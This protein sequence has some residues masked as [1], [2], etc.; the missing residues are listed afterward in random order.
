MHISWQLIVLSLAYVGVLFIIAWHGDRNTSSFGGAR[1]S[2]WVYPL[3][4]GVY[5][6]SW[7]YYG[8]VGSAAN[9][10]WEF[11]PIYLGPILVFIYGW[12]I[13]SKFNAVVKTHRVGSLADFMSARYGRSHPLAVLT[14]VIA[15]L[16]TI[17]YIALQLKA[18]GQTFNIM[19]GSPTGTDP[20]IF[21]TAFFAA[22]FLTIFAILFG[23]RLPGQRRDSN[24]GMMIAIAFESVV[25][26][27]A[28]VLVGVFCTFE[29]YDGFGN[30]FALAR[31]D[32][33]VASVF[34]AD[35][36]QWGL[37][38]QLVLAS[39]AIICLPRQFHV[40]FV[41]SPD[42]ERHRNNA[43]WFFP[44]YLLGFIIF[45]VPIAAAGLLKFGGLA[46]P[47]AFVLLLP[48]AFDNEPLAALAF[49]G[50]LS[51]ATGMILVSTLALAIM[52]SNELLLPLLFRSSSGD[53]KERQDLS[54]IMVMVRRLSIVG[55]M[56]LAWLYY[57]SATSER[58]LASIGL[59]A[60]A[61]AAQFAPALLGGLYWRQGNRYGALVGMLMGLVSWLVML[62]LPEVSDGPLQT[63]EPLLILAVDPLTNGV[64]VSLGL[65]LLTYIFV[66]LVTTPRLVD[67]VQAASFVDVMPPSSK[68]ARYL[69]ENLRID[70]LTT[71]AS[72][73]IGNNR[74][75]HIID[76]YASEHQIQQLNE[77]DPAPADL[78]AAIESVLAQEIGYTSARLVTRSASREKR[79]HLGEL[80]SLVDEAST[81]ARQNQELLRKAI[82]HLS[83]GISVVDQNQRLVAWNKRYQELFNYPGE[84]LTVGRPIADLFRYNAVKGVAGEFTTEEQ[85]EQ[86]LQKRL[87]H[88]NKGTAYRRESVLSSGI[89]LEIIGEPMPNGGY[90]T[91][92]TD[93][94]PYKDAESALRESEQA[95]RVYTDN[96]PAMIAYIDRDYRIQFI[97]KAFERTMRVWREQ[98]IGRPNQEIFTRE[99]YEAR[100]PYLERALEGRRQR[101][102]VSIDRAG[103]HREFEALYV[104]DRTDSGDIQG[105]F[106]LYQDVTDRN[107]A[108]RGLETAN[109]TLEARVD[110]RTEELQAANEALEAE[111][112]RRAET[113]KALTEAMR[114]TEEANL[115]KTRFL[116]AASHDLLQP[117]NAARLFTTSLAERA[118]NDEFRELTRHLEGA[119]SS[120]ENLISTLLEISKL[121]AGA[122]RAE[123]Q[124]FALTD[125][126]GQLSQE[127]QVIAEQRE[128]TFKAKPRDAVVQTDPKLLRR[129]LQNFLSNA[130][131]YTGPKGRVLFAIRTF[132]SDVRIEVWDNGIGMNPDD[133]PS[134]FD[135]FRRLSEGIQTEKK[136]LGLGLSIS[137]RICD[138][139]GLSLR[140]Q[141][142]PGIGS[143]F[144]LT[145][146][147]SDM[148]PESLKKRQSQRG[149][150]LFQPLT[151]RTVLV[152]DND[153][154]ILIGMQS[155][156]S[157]WGAQVVTGMTLEDAKEA[158]K[159]HSIIDVALIDYHLDD[160][161]LGIDV[162]AVLR[163]LRG[164]IECALIT[165]DRSEEMKKQAKELGA[166]VLH[167]P[168]KPAVLRSWITQKL[169]GKLPP[170]S[171]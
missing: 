130:L 141:S 35:F 9:H 84:L 171:V 28:F 120:A 111:N 36:S 58:S 15:L 17:P 170:P 74:V 49:L 57:Q 45:V 95:I 34:S 5:A 117:L 137:K 86:A 147:R 54:W 154:D 105:I 61:A 90:V 116:A 150:A 75:H 151:N 100:L 113:Q 50:G 56:A 126:F 136:G 96:V 12:P 64:L 166:T 13:I 72:R 82:E 23:T 26:L 94:S 92:Y 99:E 143:C 14:T 55:I 152:I 161:A 38:T 128:I 98:V 114:A 51:A 132:R 145:L 33:K 106:I 103:E 69:K 24:R 134:I 52:V 80:V 39:L 121:D 164:N 76:T 7:T 43:R 4:I 127:F 119:L 3:S 162:I 67:R 110:E 160:D 32:P 37:A 153:K 31:Q 158:V 112:I 144:S 66:S 83:Q 21:D 167:K 148:D 129:V 88:L 18:V 87:D 107:E 1:S 42:R 165:A 19:A 168:L 70:D 123:P 8:A 77:K 47:D 73:F 163:A 157:G 20:T 30:L 115:S 159:A 131:R 27:V 2:R 101:F 139:L 65:N 97:N 122:L 41:E 11:L 140:V 63:L 16:G 53:L 133:L 109:E 10:G 44:L 60:F 102:E 40:T 6:T 146:P 93:V 118:H 155:L 81:L 169:R 48:M 79:I 78:V 22:L 156:L 25:K 138:L 142:K 149:Q 85:I 29:L 108:K 135:E 59:V 124:A 91:S 68:S 62:V 89:T 71:L 125:L 46:P 104:P